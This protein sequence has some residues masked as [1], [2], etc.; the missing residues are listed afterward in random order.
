MQGTLRLLAYRKLKM[1][2][3]KKKATFGINL[4]LKALNISRGSGM[5]THVCMRISM[6]CTCVALKALNISRAPVGACAEYTHIYNTYTYIYTHTYGCTCAD[7]PSSQGT[8]EPEV[9][10]GP[11]FGMMPGMRGRAEMLVIPT[12]KDIDSPRSVCVCVCVCYGV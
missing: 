3:R 11:K 12:L 8:E 5:S 7:T 2:P 9:L 6:V 10:A 1:E 4:A